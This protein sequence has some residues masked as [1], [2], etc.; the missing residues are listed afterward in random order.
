MYTSHEGGSKD[1]YSCIWPLFSSFDATSEPGGKKNAEGV[2]FWVFPEPEAQKL[3]TPV[4]V[5]SS[6][7]SVM[8]CGDNE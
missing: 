3:I 8:A 7:W 2:K 6:L 5:I 4:R 1:D